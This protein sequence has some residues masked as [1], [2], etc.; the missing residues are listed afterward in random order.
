MEESLF[1]TL[2]AMNV[3]RIQGGIGITGTSIRMTGTGMSPFTCNSA[4]I[5]HL[6][7]LLKPIIDV[8]SHSDH[9][10]SIR[11]T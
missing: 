8:Y 6:C 9:H 10:I 7:I 11:F 4:D 3:S 2:T 1:I 5:R